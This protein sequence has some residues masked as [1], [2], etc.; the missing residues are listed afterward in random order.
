MENPTARDEVTKTIDEA[1]NEFHRLMEMGWCGSS[2]AAFIKD[3]LSA[4]GMLK[5]G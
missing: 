4:K 1:I 5:D 2:L 3:K